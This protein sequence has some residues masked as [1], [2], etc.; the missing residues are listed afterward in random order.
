M[1]DGAAHSGPGGSPVVPSDADEKKWQTALASAKSVLSGATAP[2]TAPDYEPKRP[3][4][5]EQKRLKKAEVEAVVA[6]YRGGMSTYQLAAKWKM[7]RHTISAI[8]DREG[9]TRRSYAAKLTDAEV[10]EAGALYADGWSMNALAKRYGVDP[11]TMKNR[12]ASV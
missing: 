5:Q 1:R 2:W 6:D 11:K 12:L 7:N 9:I 8:L 3:I 4:R 10:T